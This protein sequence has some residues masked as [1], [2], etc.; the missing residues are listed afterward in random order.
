MIGAIPFLSLLKKYITIDGN[1]IQARTYNSIFSNKLNEILLLN[2][3]GGNIGIGTGS[4]MNKVEIGTAPLL[5]TGRKRIN[6]S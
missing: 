2:P 6:A 3:F 1:S 5:G 4:P